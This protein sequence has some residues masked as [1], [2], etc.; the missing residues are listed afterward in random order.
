MN[1]EPSTGLRGSKGEERGGGNY[2]QPRRPPLQLQP[3]PSPS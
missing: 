1:N 2:F 3:Q